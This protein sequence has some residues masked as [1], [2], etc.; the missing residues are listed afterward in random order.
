MMYYSPGELAARNES[1]R[2]TYPL[3]LAIPVSLLGNLAVMSVLA[4]I[5][6]EYSL[7]SLSNFFYGFLSSICHQYPTRCL[8]IL[9]RPMGLC[10]RCFSVYASLSICLLC[11]PLIPKR[12]FMI[13]STLLFIP[14]V[15]DGL[16]QFGNIAASD[17][18]R[19]ML[20]GV[21]FGA[22]ASLIYKRSAFTLLHNLGTATE[23]TTVNHFYRNLKLAFSSGILLLTIFYCVVVYFL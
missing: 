16:L 8:W 14:L 17:N 12:K 19:R 9:N 22:A 1:S 2:I 6:E 13:L 10:S 21:L 20:T 11:L 4:P 3:L 7:Y 15:A 5:C 18:F 23:G